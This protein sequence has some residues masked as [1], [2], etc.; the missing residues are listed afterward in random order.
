MAG[1]RLKAD[2]L[3]QG[4]TRPAMMMGVSYS[5]FVVNLLISMVVFIQT[6]NPGI[7]L[8]LMP[9]IHGIGYLIC[10][11]EPRAIELFVVRFG[12]CMKCRNRLYH[13]NTNSYDA[14]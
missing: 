5:Y 6:S 8:L 10:L 12:K 11:K 7:L 2:P 9:F 13:A 4:L 1:G 14:F 3:F